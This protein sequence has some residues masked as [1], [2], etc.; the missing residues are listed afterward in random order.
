ML[1]LCEWKFLVFWLTILNKWILQHLGSLKSQ[2]AAIYKHLNSDFCA[3]KNII[4]MET[5]TLLGSPST[6]W[7]RY[8]VF[9]WVTNRSYHP[10]TECHFN[11]VSLVQIILHHYFTC[12]SRVIGYWNPWIVGLQSLIISPLSCCA[13]VYVLAG[14]VKDPPVSQSC[15][16]GLLKK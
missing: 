11:F 2:D 5:A 10:Q 3:V 12:Y 4:S 14:E 7:L 1:I 8:L 6:R 9:N 15:I 13:D 16:Q